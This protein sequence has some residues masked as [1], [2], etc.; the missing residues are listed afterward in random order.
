MAKTYGIDV[1][2]EEIK[3]IVVVAKLLIKLLIDYFTSKQVLEMVI[4]LENALEALKR[5]G[6][7]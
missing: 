6:S 4:P 2:D 5:K 7:R 3:C 1:S